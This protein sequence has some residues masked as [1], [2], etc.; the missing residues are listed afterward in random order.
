MMTAGSALASAVRPRGP[1]VRIRLPEPCKPQ[2]EVHAAGSGL[3]VRLGSNVVSFAWVR[4]CPP[5]PIRHGQ[6][7]SRT[8][9][10]PGER[11]SALLESVLGAS[12]R[13]FESRILRHADL[14][15]REVG[16]SCSSFRRPPCLSFCLI[17]CFGAR[18]RV[19]QRR[20]QLGES[21]QHL[22]ALPGA[23][24]VAGDALLGDG[25]DGG[26]RVAV[27]GDRGPVP[28]PGRQVPDQVADLAGYLA[29]HPLPHVPSGSCSATSTPAPSPRSHL[30]PRLRR[31]QHHPLRRITETNHPPPTALPGRAPP[32]STPSPRTSSPT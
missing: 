19:W 20:P 21:G 6:P 32:P 25:E 5:R 14:R 1:L 27:D 28:G 26:E 31:P 13:E 18:R 16:R 3:Q 22:R 2:D 11:W 7:R 9:A 30:L 4:G 23:A 24:A 17:R 10:N 8:V 29:A 15:R 12:P